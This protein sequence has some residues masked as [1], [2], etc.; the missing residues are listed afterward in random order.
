MARELTE[1]FKG[2][3]SPTALNR[4]EGCAGEAIEQEETV[5]GGDGK[6]RCFISP[7]G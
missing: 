2:L 3:T 4:E 6:C 5:F 7:S 1:V